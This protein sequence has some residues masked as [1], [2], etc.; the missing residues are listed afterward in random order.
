MFSATSDGVP[1]KDATPDGEPQADM[2]FICGGGQS[3]SS[4]GGGYTWSVCGQH[5]RPEMRRAVGAL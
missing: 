2:F 5:V 4:E 3:R 1:Q